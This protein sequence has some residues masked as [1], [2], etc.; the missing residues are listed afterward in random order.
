M[1]ERA[2]WGHFKAER[3]AGRAAIRT[4]ENVSDVSDKVILIR[5]KLVSEGL[6]EFGDM[7]SH[8]LVLPSRNKFWS[9]ALNQRGDQ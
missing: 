2:G 4:L 6:K 8:D 7:R 3:E 1:V 9:A 5:C